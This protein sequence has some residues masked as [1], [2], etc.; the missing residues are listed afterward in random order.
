N[1]STFG[2]PGTSNTFTINGGYNNDPFLNIGNTGAT[3][4]MLGGNDVGNVTVVSNAYDAAY[5]GLGGTQLSETTRSG[6][7]R[8]HGNANYFWNGRVMN[9]NDWFVKQ[10]GS[11]RP[12]VNANQWGVGIGGPIWRDHTFF[13]GN[14]EGIRLVF[15]TSPTQ[16]YAPSKLMQS[17]ALT[18]KPGSNAGDCKFGGATSVGPVPAS[19]VTLYNNM[20]KLWNAAPGNTQ[21]VTANDPYAVSWSAT[22]PAKATEWTAMGRIDQ[23]IGTS[24]N[25][26]VHYEQ[27]KGFQPTVTSLVNPIFNAVS[28][29]PNYNGQIGEGHTFSPNVVN[30]FLLAGTY[31]QAIFTNPNQTAANAQVPFALVFLAGSGTAKPF[32]ALS[33][34]AAVGLMGAEDYVFPQ[35]RKITG[36]QVQDD[37]SI[38]HHT[39]M[40]KVGVA[41]RRD[42][43]SDLNSSVRSVT[44]E[45]YAKEAD[46]AAGNAT[47]WRQSFP[48]KNE[49]GVA[50]YTLSGYV[51]DQ[52]KPLPNLTL[53]FG[54]RLQHNSSPVCQQNC[55]SNLS[56]DFLK[57]AASTTTST[58]YN[59]IIS[60]GLHQ[61]FPGL[62]SVSYEPRIGFAL[63]PFGAGSRTTIR[64]GF[65]IF[66]DIFPATATTNLLENPPGDVIFYLKTVTG[67]FD[68]TLPGSPAAAVRSSAAAF[69]SGFA[70]GASYKSLTTGPNPVVGFTQPT[71]TAVD[72]NLHYPT[73]DEYSLQ[74]EQQVTNSTSFAL[75]YVGNHGYH[76]PV[77]NEGINGYGALSLP[78][79]APSGSLATIT[80]I[81]SNASSNYNGA[82]VSALH[83]SKLLKLQ[84]NY[85]YSHALDEMSNGG[86]EPIG[87]NDVETPSNPYNLAQNYGNADYDTRHYVSANY[88]FT[89]PYRHG[90]RIL[91]RGWELAGTVF[92]ST[93]QPF[94]Y[95][96]S[97]T[98]AIPNSSNQV[99]AQQ[100]PGKFSTHCGGGN[101]TPDPN[102]GAGTPCDSA[103]FFTTATAYGQQHRNQMF[104]PNYT[105]SDIDILKAFSMPG[106]E[107]GKLKLGAQIYNLFNHPNFAKPVNDVA[108]GN[109]GL[110]QGDVSSPTSIF[111]SFIGGAASSRII[112][113]KGSF[114]F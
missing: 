21:T 27:D 89:V 9:A 105:D 63:L 29:Q 65:G 24:D 52:W 97:A 20:F 90:P 62:Q 111:G 66:S 45:A 16:V 46:F 107:S 78:A 104:G 28:T 98:A 1:F 108:S 36:Y 67:P 30:Q 51:Q 8:F 94:T 95:I 55:F 58:P 6:S 32:S 54:L 72:K 39:H 112:Q 19:E 12:F 84:F 35:G 43:A 82:I 42:D 76:E 61:S 41:F 110:I 74:I 93:G 73:Y 17:C 75:L 70:G 15:P 91:L 37:L 5:G 48:Q 3:N 69:R 60:S 109:Q 87:D 4:L 13:F 99:F 92:H 23:V 14:Y 88:V 101:H 103:N 79:A 53:T 44:P 106:W 11:P 68:P 56:D 10:S 77:Q 49:Y 31:Y 64:G 25:L 40:I 80:E 85:A 113:L 18:G 83:R 102:T 59:K 57:V 47:R 38:S 100:L 71:F 50:L 81:Q 114:T 96:D 7:N 22:A 34:N 86:F 26:F 2:L 33:S